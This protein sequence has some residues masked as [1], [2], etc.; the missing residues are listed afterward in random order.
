MSI[1]TVSCMTR[2]WAA[3]LLVALLAV[4][5]SSGSEAKGPSATVP[6]PK[7]TESTT[8][9]STPQTPEQEVEAA[10]LK[11]WDVYA[12]AMRTLD[13]SGL[14]RAFAKDALELR[15][16]EVAALKADGTPGRM[17]VDHHI[18]AIRVEG[19]KA[20][21]LD[22]Y[23]NHS[24][25]LDPESGDPA[26]PVPNTPN[27]RTYSLERIAGQWYVTFVLD[28]AAPPTSS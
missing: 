4:A 13:P 16:S 23:V 2:R 7:T 5:C 14:D 17:D 27:S 26:E 12:K 6:P 20:K 25:L 28:N 9:T 18:A 24:V 3:P 11:S 10:Y 21:L 1:R 8:T 15:R 22:N 19:D